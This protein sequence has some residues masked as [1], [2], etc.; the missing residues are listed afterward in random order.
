[1]RNSGVVYVIQS[2]GNGMVGGER[3]RER[4]NCILCSRLEVATAECKEAFDGVPLGV[5]T[6]VCQDNLYDLPL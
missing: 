5:S 2:Y 1:M 6:Q 3:E 4:E